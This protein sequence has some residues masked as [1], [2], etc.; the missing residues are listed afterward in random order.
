ML[1]CVEAVAPHPSATGVHGQNPGA[2]VRV[3]SGTS[4]GYLYQPVAPQPVNRYKADRVNSRYLSLGGG[5]TKD[6]VWNQ[7][8]PTAAAYP[9]GAIGQVP[10]LVAVYQAGCGN[11]D[12]Q[13]IYYYANADGRTPAQPSGTWTGLSGAEFACFHRTSAPQG[14]VPLMRMFRGEAQKRR[15]EFAPTSSPEYG[16][17][18]ANGFADDKDL[19]YVWPR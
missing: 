16:V 11:C 14:T 6:G 19:C 8:P 17:H 4:V 7:Q 5:P 15:W 12:V 3:S 2:G 10:G 13:T 18:H 9:P 1:A